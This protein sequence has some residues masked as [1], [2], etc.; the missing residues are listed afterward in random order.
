MK[1]KTYVLYLE[2]SDI[3]FKE[4]ALKQLQEKLDDLVEGRKSAI[5]ISPFYDY[6][7]KIE[8]KPCILAIEN[9]ESKNKEIIDIIKKYL[10]DIGYKYNEDEQEL[11]WYEDKLYYEI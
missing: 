7:G 4:E 9:D 1:I 5:T 2:K 3:V 8:F 6:E 10:D 11:K